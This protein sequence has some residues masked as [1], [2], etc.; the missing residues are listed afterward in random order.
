MDVCNWP[1]LTH[2]LLAAATKHTGNHLKKYRCMYD[3]NIP[4]VIYCS[5]YDIFTHV[6]NFR[7]LNWITATI[8][9]NA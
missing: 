9:P 6:L 4:D 5:K 8:P 7:S 2:F 3:L 1:R